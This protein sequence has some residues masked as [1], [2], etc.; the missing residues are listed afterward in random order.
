[1]RPKGK[2]THPEVKAENAFISAPALP[3]I[4]SPAKCLG[5]QRGRVWGREW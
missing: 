3:S 5:V 4:L 2:S 1:M